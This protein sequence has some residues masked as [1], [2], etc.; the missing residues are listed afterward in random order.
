M[1]L[2]GEDVVDG[3]LFVVFHKAFPFS[4]R[5][6]ASFL[7]RKADNKKALVPCILARNE[8]KTSAVPFLL[9]LTFA[10]ASVHRHKICANGTPDNGGG[11][12]PAY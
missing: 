1:G 11:S 3:V 2:G 12:V 5:M 4:I 8:S 6:A 9:A 7:F 10:P